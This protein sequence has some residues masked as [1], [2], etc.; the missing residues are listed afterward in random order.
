[1]PKHDGEFPEN[2]YYDYEF[3]LEKK[4]VLQRKTKLLEEEEQK[5][6]LSYKFNHLDKEDQWAL[7]GAAC[8]IIVVLVILCYMLLQRKKRL[9]QQAPEE[10]LDYSRRHRSLE[11]RTR[12]MEK[13]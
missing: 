4:R 10:D 7:I 6:E 12:S 1:M 9:S 13:N 5:K 11:K 2:Y 8:C 3:E